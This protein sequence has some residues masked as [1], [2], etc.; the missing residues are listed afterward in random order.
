MAGKRLGRATRANVFISHSSHDRV[1][2][3][4]VVAVL[5]RHGI[6]SWYAPARLLA[7]RQWHDEI[8]RALRKCDWFLLIL[9]EYSLRSKWV[10]RELNFALN[11]DRYNDS[12]LSIVKTPGDYA[13]LSW[14]LSSYQQI[15]FDEACADLLRVWGIVYQSE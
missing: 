11:A 2:A 5:Q 15:D 4:K 13:R 12:I 14:I 1:F 8:G 7:A 3:E 10:K 6:A 9:S